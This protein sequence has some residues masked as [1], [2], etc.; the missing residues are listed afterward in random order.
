MKIFAVYLR[1]NLVQKP[2]WFD[3]F[4]NKLGD[5]WIRYSEPLEE[6]AAL[7]SEFK[8]AGF[9]RLIDAYRDTRTAK[10]RMIVQR[11]LNELTVRPSWE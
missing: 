1:I 7:Y 10:S 6:G 9:N 3:E 4:R 5:T 2:S 8:A 11:A